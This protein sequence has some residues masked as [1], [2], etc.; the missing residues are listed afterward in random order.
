MKFSPFYYTCKQFRP[1]VLIDI[2][3]RPLTTSVKEAKIKTG[4][5]FPSIL[6]T[7][8]NVNIWLLYTVHVKL[9]SLQYHK[10]HKRA[11]VWLL[12]TCIRLLVYF[13]L[14]NGLHY[15]NR[16][17]RDATAWQLNACSPNNKTISHYSYKS[18]KI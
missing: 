6:Y 16:Y 15:Y 5:I 4:Q 3:I 13:Y 1:V 11:I 10:V 17:A 8:G 18:N 12:Y 9:Y 2:G 14:T 7:H